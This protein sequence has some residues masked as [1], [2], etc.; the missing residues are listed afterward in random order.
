MSI[1][2]V[3]SAAVYFPYIAPPCMALP[4]F[5]AQKH[6]WTAQRW[7]EF[8]WPDNRIRT[9]TWHKCLIYW[10]YFNS[11][12]DRILKTNPN[13]AA[14]L[15]IVQQLQF[16][17]H[18]FLS[19][20]LFQLKPDAKGQLYENSIPLLHMSRHFPWWQKN[21]FFSVC[22]LFVPCTVILSQSTFQRPLRYENRTQWTAK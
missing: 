21:P 20:V 1:P 13:L 11:V 9:T 18:F 7:A 5:F 12:S 3:N 17:I 10:K 15:L 19:S 6:L 8:I 2:S 22:Y 4:Y 14:H 16:C